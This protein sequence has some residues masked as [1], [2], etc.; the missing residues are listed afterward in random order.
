MKLN[1]VCIH[2]STLQVQKWLLNLDAIHNK[3][4]LV[5]VNMRLHLSLREINFVALLLVFECTIAR[6]KRISKR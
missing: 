3:Q 1:T 6:K 4:L 2:Y 5:F